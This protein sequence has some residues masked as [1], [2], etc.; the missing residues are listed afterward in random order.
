MASRWRNRQQRPPR[1]HLTFLASWPN[2]NRLLWKCMVL[3]RRQGISLKIRTQIT[4]ISMVIHYNAKCG[5]KFTKRSLNIDRFLQQQSVIANNYVPGICICNQVLCERCLLFMFL[6]K[7]CLYMD[8]HVCF[9]LLSSLPVK[10][11]SV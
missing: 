8:V 3:P 11:A 10:E 4:C 5:G 9:T 2:M 7:L 6:I 1:R